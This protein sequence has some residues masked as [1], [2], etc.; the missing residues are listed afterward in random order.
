MGKRKYDMKVRGINDL[1]PPFVHPDFL[2]DCLGRCQQDRFTGGFLSTYCYLSADI[3][4]SVSFLLC[5]FQF[6]IAQLY[7]LLCTAIY[8]FHF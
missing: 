7:N 2:Q 6:P 3:P 5:K 8:T 1:S 4:E